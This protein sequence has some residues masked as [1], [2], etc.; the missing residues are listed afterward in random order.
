VNQ[1]ELL[2]LVDTVRSLRCEFDTVEVKRAA[3]ETPRRLFETVSAFANSDEGGVILFGIDESS[4]FA[5]TGVSDAQKLQ[6]DVTA[7]AHNQMEPAVRPSFAVTEI[8]DH[9]VLGVRIPSTSPLQRPCFF[10]DAG[11]P[12][13]AFIRVGNTNRQMSEYEVFGYVSNREQPRDDAQAVDDTEVDDLDLAVVD[14]YLERLRK[15][16]PE[17]RYSRQPR[18]KAMRTLRIVRDVEGVPRPTLAGLL[19][20]GGAPEVVEPQLMISFVQYAGTDERA[21]GP[22]GERFLD[23]KQFA[24]PVPD[25]IDA[26]E[27]YVIGRIRTR[28]LIDGLFRREIPEYPRAAIREALVNAIAHRDYSPYARGSQVQVKLFSDRLEITSPGAL[29]GNVTLERLEESQSARNAQLVRMM[30]DVRLVENRGSGIDS[31]VEAMRVAGLEP[32]RFHDDRNQFT[33]VLKSHTLV[34]DDDGVAWLNAVADQLPLNDRQKLALLYLRRN[35][36]L[37]NSQY[38][39]LHP[40]L[41]SRDALHELQGLVECG[42]AAMHGVRGG[43]WYELALPPEVPAPEEFAT[44]EER[45][46]EYIRRQGSV[47][48]GT[49]SSLLGWGNSRRAGRFLAE[50]VARGLLQRQGKKRGT[51]Y[52]LK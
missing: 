29:Y 43:A 1:S 15:E 35:P 25:M 45:V 19:M 16:R 6:A 23:N 3:N 50:L 28:T 31:M 27:A 26:T 51:R 7:L 5:V 17:A 4:G 47:Q 40:G 11:L 41:D 39:R 36:R 46:L 8:D 14:D 18:D 48:A 34:L 30:Q 37:T 32:P 2:Q 21:Q 42:A 12:R 22:G 24:G 20:F 33:V 13:G 38:R 44:D 9:V 49:A 52:V 10:K